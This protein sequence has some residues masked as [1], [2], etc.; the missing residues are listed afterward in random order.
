ML[1]KSK[2]LTQIQNAGIVTVV[3]G[4]SKEEAYQT[5][6]AC[7]QGGVGS[8]E[9]AFTAPHADE[10]IGKLNEEYAGDADVL[11]GAGTVLDPQTARVAIIAGASYIVSPSFSEEVAKVCNSY[12]IPYIPG[13]MTPTDIQQALTFGSEIVKLFPG[14]IMGSSM[15]SELHGPFPQVKV[16]VTGG[17]KLD[18][19]AEWFDKGAKIVGVGGQM[20]GPAA[21]RDF[22]KVIENA[23]VFK[24]QVNEIRHSNTDKVLL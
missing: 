6:K 3:R 5:A 2:V 9:L 11:I 19:L 14:S 22:E 21:L 12:T 20:V 15:I 18:N 10:V 1:E 8:I 7:I 17:V 4:N 13:C 16:M 23:R 24:D